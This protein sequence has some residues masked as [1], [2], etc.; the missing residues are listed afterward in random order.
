[1]VIYEVEVLEDILLPD[2]IGNGAY[3]YCKENGLFH[4]GARKGERLFVN[5]QYESRYQG[6]ESEDWK[7]LYKAL[8]GLP[9][10]VLKATCRCFTSVER[11]KN[12]KYLEQYVS[13]SI[14]I[15]WDKLRLVAEHNVNGDE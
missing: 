10:N 9:H 3:E 14:G 1:M 2:Y 5:P 12:A 4:V 11:A 7:N 6:T 8:R 13:Q 15:D